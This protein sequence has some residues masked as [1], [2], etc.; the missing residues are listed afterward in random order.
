M[1]FTVRSRG[2]QRRLGSQEM[3]LEAA[4]SPRTGSAN[5]AIRDEATPCWQPQQSF[6]AA[7]ALGDLNRFTAPAAKM[8]WEEYRGYLSTQNPNR[9]AGGLAAN[10][11]H[12][13]K[14]CNFVDS[15]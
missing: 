9:R 6:Q 1:N 5:V 10:D 11:D 13:V 2:I 4:V 3:T 7:E 12:Q 15:R 14:P 8:R